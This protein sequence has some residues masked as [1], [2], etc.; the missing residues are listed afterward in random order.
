MIDTQKRF[1]LNACYRRN[2]AS[3]VW[4]RHCQ[5]VILA[6]LAVTFSAAAL[7]GQL[8]YR[9]GHPITNAPDYVRTYRKPIHAPPMDDQDWVHDHD[10]TVPPWL[11]T[12]VDGIRRPDRV[13]FAALPRETDPRMVNGTGK[14][15][16]LYNRSATPSSE[17][18][19]FMQG[20]G[21]TDGLGG[22]LFLDAAADAGYHVIGLTY[23]S[24]GVAIPDASGR[25]AYVDCS[26]VPGAIAG[27]KNHLIF[28]APL[29]G[30]TYGTPSESVENRLVKLLK[31]LE[32]KDPGGGWDRYLQG[33]QPA[34]SRIVIGG[35]SNGASMAAYIAKARGVA[36]VFLSSSPIDHTG[37][38]SDE[39]SLAAQLNRGDRS[40]VD[41]TGKLAGWLSAPSATP[42]ERWYGVY[43]QREPYS[44]WVP[45]AFAALK[46]PTDH[47]HS[48]A[49]MH[50]GVISAPRYSPVFHGCWVGGGIPLDDSWRPTDA[51]KK[52]WAFMIGTSP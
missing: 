45:Q 42:P 27:A 32:R 28:G 16:A 29:Q 38:N 13:A 48:L 7:D 18:V 49:L 1:R 23:D 6:C 36:R 25:R 30:A 14:N 50:D 41:L 12:T 3:L 9:P 43:H 19:V 46:I 52:I 26:N 34:W 39:E 40:A 47:V 17:L 4:L 22:G 24:D 51:V 10:D 31:Y 2:V 33:D 5:A 37:C 15:V 8:V 35:H 20:S 11:L 44:V 21:S